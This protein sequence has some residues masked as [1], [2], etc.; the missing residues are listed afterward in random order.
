MPQTSQD[1]TTWICQW[2][3]CK[4]T[5]LF[6]E[7]QYKLRSQQYGI[8]NAQDEILRMQQNIT[9]NLEENAV[10]ETGL[11]M[12]LEIL[13]MAVKGLKQLLEICLRT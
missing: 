12:T 7:K 8:H 3:S 6:K 2:I 9:Y 11:E 1:R 4:N 5:I 10:I 13:K